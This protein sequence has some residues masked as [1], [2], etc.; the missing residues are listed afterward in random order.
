MGGVE[1]W[2]HLSGSRHN[3]R[4][5]ASFCLSYFSHPCQRVP[6]SH[7][8]GSWVCTGVELDAMETR[9][10]YFSCCERNPDSSVT[11][12]CLLLSMDINHK[13]INI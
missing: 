4:L 2:I 12:I 5:V 10:I 11:E 7:W 6:I 3:W 1:V 9:T 13:E 8:L